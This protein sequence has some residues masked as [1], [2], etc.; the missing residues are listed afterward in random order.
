[1]QHAPGSAQHP[2][3][4]GPYGIPPATGN[5]NLFR[6][7]LETMPG[8]RSELQNLGGSLPH[9]L[10]PV[11]WQAQPQLPPTAAFRQPQQR[12]QQQ[13][14]QQRQQQLMQLQEPPPPPPPPQ[15]LLYDQHEA[16]YAAH[17]SRGPPPTPGPAQRMFVAARTIIGNYPGKTANQDAYVMQP[18]DPLRSGSGGGAVA[19]PLSRR[20]PQPLSSSLTTTLTTAPPTA[21][22]RGAARASN[23]N[24]EEGSSSLPPPPSRWGSQSPLGSS[25]GGG[26]GG[27]G[28]FGG[29]GGNFVG[30]DYSG[31]SPEDEL[32][33]RLAAG[34]G[35]FGGDGRSS[36]SVDLDEELAFALMQQF[37]AD[38][39]AELGQEIP[40][41][42]RADPALYD[43][44]VHER[45]AAALQGNQDS[46]LARRAN[47]LID[48]SSAAQKR[49]GKAG[50]LEQ[51]RKRTMGVARPIMAQRAII[52]VVGSAT[53][54]KRT[55]LLSDQDNV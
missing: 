37:A 44:F 10:L 9:P 34:E 52:N 49:G 16:A 12:Q 27:G 4:L 48:S 21:T 5:P 28:N 53:D 24:L 39:E 31:L 45:F 3:Q 20:S 38:M 11:P 17:A 42:V 7:P 13:R 6:R 29:G 50:F 36:P 26:G 35:D 1:M 46:E 47:N 54:S 32:A 22:G 23:W 40:A 15:Q 25:G 55:S 41:N 8:G 33:A 2:R 18:L 14:Q 19:S 51:L 43:A 30:N